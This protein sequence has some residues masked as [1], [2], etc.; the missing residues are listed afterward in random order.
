MSTSPKKKRGRELIAARKPSVSQAPSPSHSGW[1]LILYQLIYYILKWTDRTPL[2]HL[3]LQL[4]IFCCGELRNSRSGNFFYIWQISQAKRRRNIPDWDTGTFSLERWCVL[5][6]GDLKLKIVDTIVHY[7]LLQR[8]YVM[9]SSTD[10]TSS[11][12]IFP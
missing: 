7:I 2:S 11:P 3:V 8:C 10:S 5:W 6:H 12:G 4:L 9:V 1:R